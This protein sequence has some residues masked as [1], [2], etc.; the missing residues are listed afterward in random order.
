MIT[1]ARPVAIACDADT[2]ARRELTRAL[3]ALDFFDVPDLDI[4][5]AQGACEAVTEY[6]PAVMIVDEP[7]GFDRGFRERA[8]EVG[9]VV[10]VDRPGLDAQRFDLYDGDVVIHV[11][12]RTDPHAVAVAALAV[13][14]GISGEVAPLTSYVRNAIRAMTVTLGSFDD[15]DQRIIEAIGGGLSYEKASERV[16]VSVSTVKRRLQQITER[17]HLATRGDL[18]LWWR[19][20]RSDATP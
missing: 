2:A 18:A 11:Q 20:H 19:T 6:A 4:H 8:H 5:D 15:V 13:H 10:R 1:G 7:I 3:V 16:G 14:H 9:R 17:L 12:R